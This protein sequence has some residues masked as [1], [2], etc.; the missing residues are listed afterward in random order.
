MLEGIKQLNLSMWFIKN[1]LET[2]FK[3]DNVK[4]FIKRQ[5]VKKMVLYFSEKVQKIAAFAL[6][7]W[8]LETK[9][10]LENVF[11]FPQWSEIPTL[12]ASLKIKSHISTAAAFGNFVFFSNGN[13]C[14]MFCACIFMAANETWDLMWM[15][16][17]IQKIAK[18]IVHCL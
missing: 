2:P 10:S 7:S 3:I 16:S 15:G 8:F 11:G 4:A 17:P 18:L 13:S 1:W 5:I 6:L 12:P 14:Q 9:Q